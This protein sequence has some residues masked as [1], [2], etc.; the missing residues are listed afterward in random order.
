MAQHDAAHRVALMDLGEAWQLLGRVVSDTG[1]HTY[2]RYGVGRQRALLIL[3][4]LQ[5]GQVLQQYVRVRIEHD[6]WGPVVQILAVAEAAEVPLAGADLVSAL[7][8][9]ACAQR[10][11]SRRGRPHRRT[12]E[13]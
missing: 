9:D 4:G 11:G 6:A 3:H 13:G 8:R 2:Y 12:T 7:I 1:R 10:S 5:R